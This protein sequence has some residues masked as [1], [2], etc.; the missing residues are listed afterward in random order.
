MA[1]KLVA[2]LEKLDYFE[3]LRQLRLT[4][5]E[6]RFLRADLIETFKIFKGFVNVDPSTFFTLS[7]RVSRGHSLKL[8]KYQASLDIRKYSFSHRVVNEWNDLPSSIIESSSVNSFKGGL[9]LYLKD[10][11]GL[12]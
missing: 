11:R 1:T 9:D 8:Y 7:D 6:T 3:R 10:V 12:R 4:T 2:G 5:L